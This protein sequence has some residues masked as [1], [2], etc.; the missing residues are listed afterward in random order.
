[1]QILVYIMCCP[2][3]L[4]QIVES[5]TS[6]QEAIMEKYKK[7][8]KRFDEEYQALYSHLKEL[9]Y[10]R[11]T[12]NRYINYHGDVMARLK[13]NGRE[14]EQFDSRLCEWLVQDIIGGR[15]FYTLSLK[16]KNEINSLQAILSY[17]ETGSLSIFGRPNKVVHFDGPLGYA[18]NDYLGHDRLIGRTQGTINIKSLYL[19]CMKDYFLKTL[20]LQSWAGLTRGGL[21]SYVESL[22]CYSSSKITQSLSILR[23]LLA[24]LYEAGA[25]QENLAVFVPRGTYK[26]DAKLPTTYSDTEIN[27]LL[28]S[29]N[30]ASPVGKRNYAVVL[31]ITHLGLRAG[32]VASLEFKDLDWDRCQLSILQQ[33]T[34]E[35]LVLPLSNELGQ[36]IIDYLRYG[37][38]KSE[39]Q[40]I[41]LTATAPYRPFFNGGGI[42]SI[43]RQCFRNSGIRQAGRKQGS[44]SLRFSLGKRLL[45]A[46]T[47]LPIISAIYGHASTETTMRYIGIDRQALGQ[48]ALEVP[49]YEFQEVLS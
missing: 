26:S 5:H 4:I 28:S 17:S 1:M 32:D 39:A 24:Y 19:A 9:N 45:E 49:P 30:R 42:C 20:G 43:V 47:P 29:I 16:E 37:R 46:K 10:S 35:P 25:I 8:M 23:G 31:L 6:W 34:K 40:E 14:N 22:V 38:P 7:S 15:Q 3:L 44:H 33:K 12:L 41:F 13:A 36:A 21:C 11:R 27:L 48:C 18:I 2:F